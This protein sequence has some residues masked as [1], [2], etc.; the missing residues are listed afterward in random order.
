MLNWSLHLLNRRLT[1]TFEA[2]V[3][4]STRAII[5]SKGYLDALFCYYFRI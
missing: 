1:S 2:K 3:A 5:A 4:R